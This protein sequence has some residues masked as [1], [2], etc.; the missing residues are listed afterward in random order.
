MRFLIYFIAVSLISFG[1]T[2][3]FLS[4]REGETPFSGTNFMFLVLIGN[5][6]SQVFNNYYLETLLVVVSFI[7][8][9]FIFTLLIGIAIFS[10]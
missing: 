1:F 4:D 7:N 9:F 8:A 6:K 5:Y 2:F 3:Y 10:F